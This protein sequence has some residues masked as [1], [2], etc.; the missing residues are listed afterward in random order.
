MNPSTVTFIN[1][2]MSLKKGDLGILRSLQSQHL[3][4]SL[5]G[6]DLFSGIWWP[7]RKKNQYAPRREVAWLIAKLY[8]QFNFAQKEN[9]SLPHVLGGICHSLKKQEDRDTFIYRF[10]QLLNLDLVHL[11]HPLNLFLLQLGQ[12]QRFFLDWVRLTEDLSVWERDSIRQKWAD[13][14]YKAYDI[15]QSKEY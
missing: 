8:A 3:D 14:F 4:E 7:L 6:F 12:H 5:A 9:E 15:K 2:L 10:D 11:E 13:L 1:S